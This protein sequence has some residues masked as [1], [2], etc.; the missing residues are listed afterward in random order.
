MTYCDW[1]QKCYLENLKAWIDSFG[2]SLPL[3]DSCTSVFM[4]HI[5]QV[6]DC[7]SLWAVDC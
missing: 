1:L 5:E 3:V 4:C 6:I 7:R 2:P